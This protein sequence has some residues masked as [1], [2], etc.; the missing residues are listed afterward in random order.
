[1]DHVGWSSLPRFLFC[2][3]GGKGIFKARFAIAR[4]LVLTRTRAAAE[5]ILSNT[6]SDSRPAFR[7]AGTNT[8]LFSNNR[9]SM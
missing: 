3:R 6:Y 4:L 8:R 5:S 2:G 7:V 9:V 1:M